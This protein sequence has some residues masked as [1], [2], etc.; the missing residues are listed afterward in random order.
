MNG[1]C[2]SAAPRFV[3]SLSRIHL[4]LCCKNCFLDDGYAIATCFQ[5]HIISMSSSAAVLSRFSC[6]AILWYHKVNSTVEQ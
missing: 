1:I 4:H 2:A 6:I 5:T 3:S